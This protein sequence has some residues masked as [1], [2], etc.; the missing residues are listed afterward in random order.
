MRI[1]LDYC[2]HK[3]FTAS[4][5]F[6]GDQIQ[7]VGYDRNTIG[8]EPEEWSLELVVVIKPVDLLEASV[9]ALWPTSD[10]LILPEPCQL[11]PCVDRIRQR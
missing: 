4:L 5:V 11:G 3:R 9:R 1:R 8:L 10:A 6:V 2:P 7:P